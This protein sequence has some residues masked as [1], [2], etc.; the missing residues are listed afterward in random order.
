MPSE[1]MGWPEPGAERDLRE[2][3]RAIPEAVRASIAL[4][5]LTEEGLPHFHRILS[6]HLIENSSWAKWRN[7]WTA[8]E[9]RHG[10]VLQIYVRAAALFEPVALERM[11]FEYLRQGVEVE[12]DRD[13]YKVLVYTALQ[14][15]AT[16]LAHAATG[17]L[18]SQ[19]EPTIGKL[20]QSISQDEARHYAFYRAA[21]KE[22]LARDPNEALVS[23]LSIMPGIDMPGVNIHQFSELAQIVRRAGIYGPTEYR[24]IVIELL[25]FWEIESL[26]GLDGRGREAQ[27]K[28]MDIPARIERLA[29]IIESRRRRKTFSLEIIVG[30]E[31]AL[32]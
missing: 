5:L 14:E 31:F 6:A 10:L 20:L 17:K 24:Q 23:A 3:A 1:L 27:E 32:D 25:R 15:R 28:L 29:S 18:G 22:V 26:R 7:L 12:W 21:F 8:E 16:Q 30:S 19:D 9:D 13:P 2:R 11:Q 4:N